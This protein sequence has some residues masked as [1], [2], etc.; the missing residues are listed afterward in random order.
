MNNG[1][2]VA[3]MGEEQSAISGA[4][5]A[6][7]AKP[8]RVQRE[9][10]TCR[11]RGFFDGSVYIGNGLFESDGSVIRAASK[12]MPALMTLSIHHD[13]LCLAAAAIDTHVIV[14]SSETNRTHNSSFVFV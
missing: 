11:S 8:G 3:D 6:S 1:C 7:Y 13:S 10:A 2:E 14:A 4:I 5:N 9:M 12:A